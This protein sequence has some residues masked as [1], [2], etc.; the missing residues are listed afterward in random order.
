MKLRYEGGWDFRA[1]DR[2][3]FFWAKMNPGMGL[4]QK[5]PTCNGQGAAGKGPL[6][7]ANKIDY[8]QLTLV[9]EAA[10]GRMSVTI[11]TPYRHI[12]FFPGAANDP[13]T[14]CCG[15][16]GFADITIGTKTLLL[17]CELM[18][19]SFQFKTYIPTGAAVNG[20]G[21]QHVSLEPGFLFNICV[22]PTTY[23]QAQTSYWIPIGGDTVFQANIWHSHI[24][25]NHVLWCPCND[26]KVIG[27]AEVNEWSVFDG[28]YTITDFGSA[29]APV[30]TVFGHD[31]S[32]TIVSAGPGIRGI[33]CDKYDLGIGSAFALTGSR[34]ATEEIRVEFRMRF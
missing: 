28:A 7:L 11:E 33:L 19:L 21:T 4:I 31:G 12:D 30:K 22:S 1:V 34:W 2:G 17:D 10:T 13:N 6:C 3:E 18:Q 16:S 29:A 24:A 23:I 5:I 27:T 32:A 25:L 20:M 15:K 8:E 9:N 26:L 14:V